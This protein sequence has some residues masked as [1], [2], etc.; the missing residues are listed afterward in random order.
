MRDIVSREFLVASHFCP[1]IADTILTTAWRTSSPLLSG[2]AAFL[3]LPA[4]A[5]FPLLDMFVT[6]A[7]DLVDRKGWCGCWE[8]PWVRGAR[9]MS[10]ALQQCIFERR[11]DCPAK[12]ARTDHGAAG[13]VLSLLLR[14]GTPTT[15]KQN[16][17][18]G[19][20]SSAHF[21]CYL[22]HIPS[23]RRVESLEILLA[24][25]FSSD[26]SLSDTPRPRCSSCV[27]LPLAQK[28]GTLAG[29]LSLLDLFTRDEFWRCLT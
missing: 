17:T 15:P 18:S 3:P 7:D 23:S 16:P 24:K 9:P 25:L 19:N 8:M 29:A 26:R 14:A 11:L 20:Y 1:A 10:Q 21:R 12:A 28:P 6:C 27:I 5:F 13:P 2:F 4:P 22:D